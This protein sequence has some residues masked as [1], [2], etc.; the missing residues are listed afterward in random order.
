MKAILILLAICSSSLLLAQ[1][2]NVEVKDLAIP[3]SPAF[4][5]MDATPSIIQTPVAPRS[6]V[7]GIVESFQQSGGAFPQEYSAEFAPYWWIRPNSK[8][9]FDLVGLPSPQKI[10]ENPALSQKENRFSG[11]K[12]TTLSIGF[13]SKDM[14]PDTSGSP[15][16]I[17]SAGFRTTLVKIHRSGYAAKMQQK[18][19]AW[20]T[21]A[22]QEMDDNMELLTEIARHPEQANELKNRFV[23][24]GTGQLVK[25]INEMISQ[26]PV[27]SW[28]IAAAYATY[29][30]G[31]TVWKTGRYAVWT[32]LSSYLKLGAENGKTPMNYANI[33]LSIRYN[34]DQYYLKSAGIAGKENTLDV[35][36]K[37][38]FESEKFSLGLESI[39]RFP[40]SSTDIQSRT[41]GLLNVKVSE[42]LYINGAFGKNFDIPDKLI[43]LF[44]INWGFGHEKVTL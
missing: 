2:S 11:I 24:A 3:S 25:D 41:V 14:I 21:A 31:D 40:G 7:L 4:I 23:P 44:G 37:I 10:K 8:S 28:D 42:N 13:F 16:K 6:F 26:K 1:N 32:T 18:I 20:H 34:A 19:S 30:I 39:Y 9:I 27:F 29:G 17:V 5:L 35:G 43:A 12:F 15:Q 36:G 33:N 38:A 22:Q